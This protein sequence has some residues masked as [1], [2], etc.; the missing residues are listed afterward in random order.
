[1]PNKY[2]IERLA[3]IQ[4]QLI[5][6]HGGGASMSSAS[7]GT[8]REDFVNKFLVDM[9]PPPFRF[10]NGDVTDSRGEKSGQLDIVVEYPFLPSFPMLGGNS[11]LYL[12]EGVA[13][14]IEV[15]SS[16]DSQWGEVQNTAA[17]V[18]KLERSFQ[19]TL[20]TGAP[21]L[22]QIPIFAVGYAGWK[23]QSTLN[24]KILNENI[25]AIL[26]IE[27]GL[28]IAKDSV[29]GLTRNGLP[30]GIQACGPLGLWW[31]VHCLITATTSLKSA[32]INTLRYV[33]PSELK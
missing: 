28:F 23:E 6:L 18:K 13:A 9:L 10:G 1:M 21:P 2:V 4:K 33:T 24:E 19:S 22:P 16:I 20:S 8:E 17:A 14:V 31:L 3:G 30:V 27:N 7:K 15:K 25:D 11:R 32:S 26:V 29:S 5:A 12:A